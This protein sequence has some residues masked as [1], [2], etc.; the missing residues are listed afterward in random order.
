VFCRGMNTERGVAQ[1]GATK[2]V[3]LAQAHARVRCTG[4]GAAARASGRQVGSRKGEAA[5]TAPIIT[6]YSLKVISVISIRNG[7]YGPYLSESS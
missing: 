3:L 5:G 4:A 7:L 6:S 2:G 1:R